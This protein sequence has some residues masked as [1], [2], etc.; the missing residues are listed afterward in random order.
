[1]EFQGDSRVLKYKAENRL[2]FREAAVAQW[3]SQHVTV[4]EVAGSVPRTCQSRVVL[5]ENQSCL[6]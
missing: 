1:M 4:R 5:N 2:K 6:R 3:D